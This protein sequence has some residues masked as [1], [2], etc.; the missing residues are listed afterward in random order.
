M[1]VRAEYLGSFICLFG[2]EAWGAPDV[3]LGLEARE[4]PYVC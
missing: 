1:C 2:L 4:A 3:S